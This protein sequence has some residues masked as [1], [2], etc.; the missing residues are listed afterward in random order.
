MTIKPFLI[1]AFIAVSSAVMAQNRT[2]TELTSWQF[3]RNGDTWQQV[4][5]PH[6]WAIKGPF[7]KQWDRQFLGI[8]Q[9]GQR[10]PIW[11][12]GR[13]GGL[14]WLGRGEYRTTI[15]VNNLNKRT[16]LYFDGAMSEPIVYVNGNEAGRWAYGYNA[17][18]INITPFLKK[19]NNEIHV[20][21]NNLEES[22]RWYPGA[23]LYRPVKLITTNKT[24]IDPWQTYFVTQTASKEIAAI[25][26]KAQAKGAKEND[27]LSTIITLYDNKGHKVVQKKVKNNEQGNISTTFD[28]Q[29]PQLWSPENPYLYTL[30]IRIKRG[31]KEIDNT[32]QKVGIRTISVS[33]EHGFQLNGITRKFKGVCL[34]HDLG[35][36]GAAAN[37]AAMIRQIRIMKDMGADAIRTSH[38][39]PSQMQMQVCDSMGMMVMAESFDA[40]KE[41]KVK[42]DYNRFYDK[43]WRKD[44]TNLILGHRNHPCIVM[45]SIGNEIPEQ[46]TKQ[47]TERA[48]AMVDFCHSLDNT[49]PVTCGVDNPQGSTN[50]GFY[51]ITD[52]PGFNYR[53]FLY[54][55]LIHKLPQGFLLGSETSS[56]VSSRGVY[57]FPV[58]EKNMATYADGQC[59]SYDVE[60]VSWGS[61]PDEDF[62]KQDDL[63]YTIGQFVWT[64]IDYIGEPTPYYSYWPSRSSYFAPVDL[65]GLPKD[66]YYLYRSVWNTSSPTL[67]LL[68][69]WTWPGREGKITPVYCYTSYPEAELFVNGKSQGRIKKNKASKLDR[70]RLRWNNVV[71]EPGELK[72]VAYDEKGKE[73]TQ[74]TIHTAGAPH[75]LKIEVDKQQLANDGKDLLYYTI[76]MV[77]KDGNL[78]PDANDLLV[79]EVSGA[80][81]FKAVCNGDATSLEPFHLPNMH[82]FHGKLV[83]TVQSNGLKGQ[84]HLTAKAPQLGISTQ[85][86]L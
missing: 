71:Y 27:K 72:V 4:T 56:A 3:S 2:E 18:R 60:K 24:F 26:V 23:G 1:S 70:Y 25:A 85:H 30:S 65:A 84:V 39:M 38:N 32:T 5:V 16:E 13:S 28:V 67:H 33:K 52:I 20:L 46:A 37:K 15:C 79:F 76:S 81:R 66:R 53:V 57:K 58:E 19:G 7:D 69:H 68:P 48:K 78:C 63:P 14:P 73:A 6:D 41:P 21:L 17:F 34:H 77:D 22:S 83:V 54:E 40:W 64:G 75:A 74:Q 36:L 59:S 55:K 61:F 12:T 80:A 42:N 43:W 29:H 10:T 44:L 9:D 35:P 51:A 62:A 45:W 50:C 82:L 49:R 86:T 47:G 11:H 31:N 8:T